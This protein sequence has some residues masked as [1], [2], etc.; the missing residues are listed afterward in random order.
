MM[1]KIGSHDGK[2]LNSIKMKIIR[3]IPIVLMVFHI[4]SGITRV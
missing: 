1:R 4:N 3:R 2:S